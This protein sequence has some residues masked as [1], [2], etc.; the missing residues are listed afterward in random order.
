[1]WALDRSVAKTQDYVKDYVFDELRG[2]S[3]ATGLPYERARN[4]M[5][6]GELSRG[7]CSMFGA[8]DSATKSR[9]GKLLQLRAL[10]WDTDGPFKNHAAIV[11]YHPEEGAGN[12]W[13]NLGFGGWTASVT[14][15][16]EKQLGISEI[17]VTSP[18]APKPLF[19]LRIPFRPRN[20]HVV[21][22]AAPR[23]ACPIHGTS[24]TR[25]RRRRRDPARRL[26]G[27]F[28]SSPR[29]RRDPLAASHGIST[30]FPRRYCD[31]P[32]RKTPADERVAGTRTIASGPSTTSRRATPSATC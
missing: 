26:R 28:T 9:G 25:S 21:S 7:A 32:P 22:A 4:M 14:G 29:R 3:D 31:P 30:T 11:V 19:P 16:S 10:D 5:W 20:I 24:A 17:G 13:A 23:P 12:A 6:I 1:M 2:L 27:I 15:F 18:A 8:K